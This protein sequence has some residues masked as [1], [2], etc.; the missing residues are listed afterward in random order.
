MFN[1]FGIPFGEVIQL[2]FINTRYFVLNSKKINL[3]MG[4]VVKF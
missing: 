4:C 3:N 1:Q 2:T